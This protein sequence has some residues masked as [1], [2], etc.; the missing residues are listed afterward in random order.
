MQQSGELTRI[1]PVRLPNGK[2]V[3]VQA[4]GPSGE[5]DVGLAER[6]PSFDEITDV[7][8]GVSSSILDTLEKVK[9]R[10]ASVGFGLEVSFKEG[11]LTALLVRGGGTASINV[12]LG[13]GE[14]G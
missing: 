14:A 13:W 5:R 10:S 2:V 1:V 12:T 3:Q 4:T 6:L 7:I 8:E 11:Q 9:P